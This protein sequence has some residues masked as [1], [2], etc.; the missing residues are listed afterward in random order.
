MEVA[1][2]LG[3][4][5]GT[6][7]FETSHVGG[8][9][10]RTPPIPRCALEKDPRHPVAAGA[11]AVKGSPPR[12]G[13]WAGPPREPMLKPEVPV[14]DVLPPVNEKPPDVDVVGGVAD[15]V[16]EPNTKPPGAAP[17]ADVLALETALLSVLPPSPKPPG[18]AGAG[19]VLPRLSFGV[20][21]PKENPVAPAAGVVET[22]T[23]PGRKNFQLLPAAHS[24]SSR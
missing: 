12:A 2:P 16:A 3:T 4:P 21:L 23:E 1:G 17:W 24:A 22:N 6:R 10:C 5:L 8:S 13:G 20:L 7:R 19:A 11:A 18:W 9:T 14:W 15:A